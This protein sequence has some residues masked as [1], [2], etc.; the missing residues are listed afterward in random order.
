M[1]A[2]LLAL[3]KSIYYFICW[4][5]INKIPA[6]IP[7]REHLYSGDNCLDPEGVPWWTFH[8]LYW[9]DHSVTA[10]LPL[11]PI[12]FVV[13]S[14][15]MSLSCKYSTMPDKFQNGTLTMKTKQKFAVHTWKR[16]KCSAS[17]AHMSSCLR[18]HYKDKRRQKRLNAPLSMR[19]SRRWARREV[20]FQPTSPYSRHI[21]RLWRC[22]LRERGYYLF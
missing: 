9:I 18:P 13:D 11:L 17:G 2:S 22:C 10:C 4:L 7:L 14:S 19:I 20:G 1:G 12:P 21:W 6:Q 5:I 3:A 15:K 8:R 16:I